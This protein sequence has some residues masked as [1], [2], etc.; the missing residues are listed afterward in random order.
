MESPVRA[1]QFQTMDFTLNKMENI[2]KMIVWMEENKHE[3][4]LRCHDENP[5]MGKQSILPEK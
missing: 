3:L 2:R 1:R 4:Q 5:Y